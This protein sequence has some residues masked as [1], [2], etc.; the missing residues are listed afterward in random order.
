MSFKEW[1]YD[2]LVNEEVIYEDDVD[3][4]E[5]TK[6]FILSATDLEES[7]INNYEA[8]FIE[9]CDGMAVEP[10]LDLD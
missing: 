10:E 4:D 3:K 1:L 8:Q 5:F 2:Q 6:D 9:H 7:D